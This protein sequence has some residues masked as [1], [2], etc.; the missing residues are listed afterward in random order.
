[1]K[2]NDTCHRL[3][4][5]AF[6]LAASVLA[7]FSACRK[8]DATIDLR[9]VIAD[10]PSGGSKVFVD[11]EKYACWQDGDAV[12]INGD[13]YSVDVDPGDNRAATI[14]NVTINES[15]G[16]TAAYPYAYVQSCINKTVTL[17][18]PSTQTFSSDADGQNIVAPM[19]GY[20]DDP[21]PEAPLRFHN[22]AGVLKINVKNSLS[23]DLNIY[24]LEIESSNA[25]IAGTGTVDGVDTPT[26]SLTISSDKTKNVMLLCNNQALASDS[27]AE[28]EIVVAPFTD[29]TKFTVH[30]LA[31]GA[32]NLKYTFHRESKSGITIA[33]NQIGSISVDVNSDYTRTYDEGNYFWGQGTPKCPFI[34]ACQADL[35]RL[36]YLVNNSPGTGFNYNADTVCYRQIADITLSS[37]SGAIG[38]SSY[39]FSANYDGGN[40]FV[41][42][43]NSCLFEYV[44]STSTHACKISNVIT[45][46][47]I[48]WG[49]SYMPIGGIVSYIKANTVLDNCT[50]KTTIKT[51]YKDNNASNSLY[52]HG[53]ICGLI[54]AAN[55]TVKIINCTN[56]GNIT[57]NYTCCGGI[58]GSCNN[59]TITFD[60]CVNTGTITST[61][62]AVTSALGGIIGSLLI[63]SDPNAITIQS[64]TN[65]GNIVATTKDYSVGGIVGLCR[66]TC[67][68][69]PT[70][71]DCS[72]YGDITNAY[73]C[74]G[75]IG[76]FERNLPSGLTLSGTIKNEGEISGQYFCGG[77][78]GYSVSKIILAENSRITNN[79]IIQYS[80]KTT[81][82]TYVSSTDQDMT[83]CGGIIGYTAG[84]TVNGIVTNTGNVVQSGATKYQYVGGIVGVCYNGDIVFNQ[85]TIKNEGVIVGT[86][87]TGGVI[88]HCGVLSVTNSTITNK[89]AVTGTNNVGG[90]AGS[91]YTASTISNAT[92]N[93]NISGTYNVAGIAGYA[94]STS[95]ISNATNNGNISGTY[96]VGGI[97][98]NVNNASSS[99]SYAKNENAVTG[100][101]SVGG[102]V[103]KSAG[104]TIDHC[105]NTANITSTSS[106]SGC[107]VAGIVGTG[108][109]PTITSSKNSGKIESQSSGSNIAYVSG[110][111]G[112]SS[113]GTYLNCA[114]EGHIRSSGGTAYAISGIV[115]RASGSAKIANCY[116]TG[117]IEGN[118]KSNC[119]AGVLGSMYYSGG[120]TY[121][122][123]C[124]N[125]GNFITNTTNYAISGEKPVGNTYVYNCYRMEEKESLYQSASSNGGNANFNDSYELTNNDVITMYKYGTTTAISTPKI[126]VGSR[127][128]NALNNWR[129]E[130][131]T[132]G[133]GPFTEWIAGPNGYPVL[134][135]DFT[136]PSSA[137]RR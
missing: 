128:L 90:I 26:P 99:I 58:C 118:S 21:T 30:V 38:N 110:I 66:N 101:Y 12:K 119:C 92:N 127:L 117:T 102:I 109:G 100:T 65:R 91:I 57:R 4:P 37:F 85:A 46:G 62:T 6:L 88:G 84:L 54:D 64:C 41:A 18:M 87:N 11:D 49:N 104:M 124:Y 111:I 47:S 122:Q 72:N 129:S 75:I 25:Y 106:S 51:A 1:M 77:I 115:G 29:P 108:G 36:R 79:A 19:A 125:V 59:G 95:T 16:Y 15:G 10:R 7:A 74:G 40:H 8:D 39:W 68:K 133:Y 113:G 48:N 43:L 81:S 2:N 52:G 105:Q 80:G 20:T 28:F 17:T 93:G 121:I 96:N 78:I 42:G 134:N 45:N 132:L 33:R 44:G 61:A 53:G 136:P 60:G 3:I 112:Y 94:Y 24:A 70:I 126:P 27:E 103:G 120:N 50:N 32:D 83:G 73:K 14:S 69:A 34:I 86:T 23:Q 130:N 31:T 98:G 97:A 131:N 116:N 123:N 89:G 82:R 22:V 9:A 56:A 63:N 13:Q 137:K 76:N 55:Y 107:G 71:T 35:E 135:L 114:N 5:Y 67:M